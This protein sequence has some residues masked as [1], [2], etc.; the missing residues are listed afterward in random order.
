MC[1][2]GRADSPAHTQKIGHAPDSLHWGYGDIPSLPAPM[3]NP[4]RF[5]GESNRYL[6]KEFPKLDRIVS[7]KVRR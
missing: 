1:C 4:R 6:D 7:I 3:G 5:Y 2:E